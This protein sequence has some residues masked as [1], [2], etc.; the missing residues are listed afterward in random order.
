L[1]VPTGQSRASAISRT[2]RV[3]AVA[4]EHGGAL[5]WADPAQRLADADADA[6]GAEGGPGFD[7]GVPA[8]Q[9]PAADPR[10]A[11]RDDRPPDQRRLVRGVHRVEAHIGG[12][13]RRH[14][15]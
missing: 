2:G 5:P 3:E 10:R 6:V 15:A 8:F 7:R 9:D 4:K 14:T 11:A 12:R 1:T 13:L